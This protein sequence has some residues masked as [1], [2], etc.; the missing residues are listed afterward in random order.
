MIEQYSKTQM[1]DS[2]MELIPEIKDK[3]VLEFIS[4]LP[5]YKSEEIISKLEYIRDHVVELDCPT[6]EENEVRD[7]AKE[8]KTLEEL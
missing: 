4:I 8:K 6:C 5:K 7:T 3:M 1:F 2:V